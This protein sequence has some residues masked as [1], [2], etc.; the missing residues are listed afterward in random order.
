MRQTARGHVA[1]FSLLD[2]EF[3]ALRDYADNIDSREDGRILELISGSLTGAPDVH[4]GICRFEPGDY[5]IKHHHPAGSEWYLLL[6]GE[7]LVHLDGVDHPAK[8]G[9]V[10]YIPA[11]VTHA[12]RATGTETVELLFGISH[13]E[14]A[15]IGLVYDE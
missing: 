7:A 4:I 12:L 15:D 1:Q 11:G 9:S 8:R 5:H 14:Y 6:A 13:A 10:F 3:V 2:D